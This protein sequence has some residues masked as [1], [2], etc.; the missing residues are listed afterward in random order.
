MGSGCCGAQHHCPLGTAESWP[1][2]VLGAS[3]GFCGAGM[4][5]A[6]PPSSEGHR[7]VNLDEIKKKNT[8]KNESKPESA[9]AASANRDRKD[10]TSLLAEMARRWGAE[11]RGRTGSVLPE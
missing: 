2:F 11:S 8:Q 5:G 4:R 3:G 9:C 6:R 10:S 1:S 7:D